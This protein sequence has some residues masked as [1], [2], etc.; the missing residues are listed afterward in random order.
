M[1][2][3]RFVLIND[4][5][6][7][8]LIIFH[9]LDFRFIL[10]MLRYLMNYLFQ[11]S[12]ITLTNYSVSVLFLVSLLF[13]RLIR[14]Y[15]GS[16]YQLQIRPQKILSAGG[17]K[18]FDIHTIFCEVLFRLNIMI[19]KIN[20]PI[21]Q[22]MSRL[23]NNKSFYFICCNFPILDG[24]IHGWQSLINVRQIV[25]CHCSLLTD[26]IMLWIAENTVIFLFPYILFTSFMFCDFLFCKKS[27]LILIFF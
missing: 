11:L 25:H 1:N 23:L 6:L 19:L 26:T 24:A 17:T 9:F 18:N 5:L 13:I 2:S 15:F 3:M 12:F 20:P 27:E 4:N 22:N 14:P 21:Y 10:F 16:F 8:L 7:L